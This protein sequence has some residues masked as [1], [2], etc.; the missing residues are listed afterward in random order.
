MVWW[1]CDLDAHPSSNAFDTHGYNSRVGSV[2][3]E[4]FGCRTA[5]RLRLRIEGYISY[6]AGTSAH[7]FAWAEPT[8][9]DSQHSS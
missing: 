1:A 7:F 4:V 6:A 2:R 9:W 3:E 5:S 8:S